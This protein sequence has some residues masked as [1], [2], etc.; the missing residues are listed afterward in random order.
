VSESLRD[1]TNARRD[2]PRRPPQAGAAAMHDDAPEATE[3]GNGWIGWITIFA[4]VAVV[5]FLV[6]LQ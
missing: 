4:Y 5:A 1:G 6:G 3:T 2:R